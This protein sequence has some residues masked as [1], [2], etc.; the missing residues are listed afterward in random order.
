MTKRVVHNV[1]KISEIT[2]LAQ[3]LRDLIVHNFTT[4]GSLSKRHW[5]DS[6][7][8]F[9][10]LIDN[11]SSAVTNVMH[12]MDTHRNPSHVWNQVAGAVGVLAMIADR[13]TIEFDK[14]DL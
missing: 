10:D 3:Y 9:N 6:K 2:Q 7:V 12:S 8:S 11:H 5:R 1:N 14:E 4:K 13:Y